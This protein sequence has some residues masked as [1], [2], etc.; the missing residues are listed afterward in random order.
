M[1][2]SEECNLVYSVCGGNLW[3][4]REFAG[5]IQFVVTSAV[6]V[7]MRKSC[8]EFSLAAPAFVVLLPIRENK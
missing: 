1:L 7:K 2:Y 8:E 6:D 4:V 5:V 3:Y